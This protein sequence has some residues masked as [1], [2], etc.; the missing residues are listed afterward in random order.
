MTQEPLVN[1]LKGNVEVDETYVGGKYKGKCGRG[2][3]GKT[4]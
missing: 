2:A 3:E 4:L 1:L